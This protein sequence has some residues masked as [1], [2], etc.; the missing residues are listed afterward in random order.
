MCKAWPIFRRT[1]SSIWSDTWFCGPG[2]SSIGEAVD[3]NDVSI[4][5][6]NSSSFEGLPSEWQIPL[7]RVKLVCVD[8]SPRELGKG[9]FGVVYEA[10][11]R[12]E[13]AAIKMVSGSESKAQARLLHEITVQEKC[14]S[15][16]T[17][18][19]L[20]YSIAGSRLLLCMELMAGGS[21]YNSLR[22]SD[23]FQW[24]NRSV[25][26]FMVH[27]SRLLRVWN[28]CTLFNTQLALSSL[29][30]GKDW[31][32]RNI[33]GWDTAAW[34]SHLVIFLNLSKEKYLSL[35]SP[36]LD[37]DIFS[38]IIL[39]L[40]THMRLAHWSCFGAQEAVKLGI[41]DRIV[42]LSICNDSPACM[43][44]SRTMRHSPDPPAFNWA[45]LQRK[46]SNACCDSWAL[47]VAWTRCGPFG[48]EDTKFAHYIRQEGQDCWLWLGQG[49][50]WTHCK[51]YYSSGKLRLDGTRAHSSRQSG[52]CKWPLVSFHYFLGGMRT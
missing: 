41:L 6:S 43:C 5:P 3:I 39:A 20:G 8:N 42:E 47:M 36:E 17:V 52:A 15:M 29:V 34:V 51:Y 28:R 38:F 23:E 24:Y 12:N 9:G 10:I 30:Y 7:D 19:F 44:Y 45:W 18:H 26:I 2:A 21:L 16:H 22:Q 32:E 1:I 50:C 25:I 11:V 46:G 4:S 14:K 27:I 37:Q 13:P 48:P 35:L 33:A 49:G 31:Q 40:L